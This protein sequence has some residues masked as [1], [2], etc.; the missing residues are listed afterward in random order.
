MNETQL[1][2]IAAA[3][4]ATMFGL[5]TA[6]LGWI[7]NK[8]YAKIDEMGDTMHEIAAGLHEKFNGLDKR[9]TVIETKQHMTDK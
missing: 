4:V 3:L 2:T 7:G 6:V 8:L 5:L 1:L 9:V